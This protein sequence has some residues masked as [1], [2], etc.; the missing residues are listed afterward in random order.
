MYI[1]VH[2]QD[3]NPVQTLMGVSTTEFNGIYSKE[4]YCVVSHVTGVSPGIKMITI[5]P[6]D[7]QESNAL[8]T[9]S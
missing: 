9:G 3:C 8:S 7:L 4:T 2:S 6:Q 1:Q 5:L